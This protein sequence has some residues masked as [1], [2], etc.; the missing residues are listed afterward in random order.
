MMIGARK[1]CW[2]LGAVTAFAGV[3][4]VRVMPLQMPEHSSPIIATGGHLL[5]VLG[6]FIITLGTRRNV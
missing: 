2:I 6:L 1:F 3:A 5:A 4:V